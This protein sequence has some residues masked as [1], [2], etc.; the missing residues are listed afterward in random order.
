MRTNKQLEEVM[1]DEIG[2][3]Y[4][5]M[6]L[7]IKFSVSLQCLL[8]SI[9]NVKLIFM[10]C[11]DVGSPHYRCLKGVCMLKIHLFLF[12]GLC[13]KWNKTGKNS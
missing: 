8:F 7:F 11:S 6:W 13:S 10:M 9:W 3:V 12:E 1:K 2:I 4:D 5:Y